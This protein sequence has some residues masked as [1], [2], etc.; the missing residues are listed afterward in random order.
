M[1]PL[2][3]YVLKIVK[4][5]QAAL[6]LYRHG[7]RLPDELAAPA[8]ELMALENELGLPFG[9]LPVVET[10]GLEASVALSLA[11][12]EDLLVLDV[13]E[14][15][16]GGPAFVQAPIDALPPLVVDVADEEVKSVQR[17]MLTPPEQQAISRSD[18][19]AAPTGE[20]DLCRRCGEALRPGS[21]FCH[22]C[23]QRRDVPI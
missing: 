2:Q 18:L 14:E 23:G 4:L 5:G 15:V 17:A 12:D 8:H 21:R 20:P 19:H 10:S 9:S 6:A 1:D 22:H 7:Q 16:G 3:T 13:E 11:G